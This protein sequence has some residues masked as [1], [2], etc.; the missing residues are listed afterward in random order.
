MKGSCLRALSPTLLLYYNGREMKDDTN[1]RDLRVELRLESFVGSENGVWTEYKETREALSQTKGVTLVS[2]S[3]KPADILHFHSQGPGYIWAAN[4]TQSKIVVSA[5]VVPDSFVGS[6]IGAKWGK[7]F[8]KRYFRY[9]YNLADLVFAVSPFIKKKLEELDINTNIE[10][11]PNFVDREKFSPNS[12]R[13]SE[14]REELGLAK[15]KDVVMAV[16]QVQPRKGVEDF[17]QV[18]KQ[19]PEKEF[20]WVG[21]CL[22]GIISAGS[23]Q[24]DKIIKNSPENA[25]FPGIIPYDQIHKYYNAADLFFLPSHQETFGLVILEAASTGLPLLLRD[26]PE[27]ESIFSDSY[28]KGSSVEEFVGLIQDILSKENLKKEYRDRSIAV[29]KRYDKQAHLD[30][31]L[32]H[33]K[34]LLG[35]TS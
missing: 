1:K 28:L 31:L 35:R 24:M 3:N 25:H 14:V 19:L 11:L 15:D 17:I 27:Y 4:R 16:G 5:H 29:A 33:Y 26:I 32:N 2:D 12:N 34:K 8:T 30:N 9:S 18:A 22:Y 23:G 21:G 13:R 7:P 20:V 6:I 10:V